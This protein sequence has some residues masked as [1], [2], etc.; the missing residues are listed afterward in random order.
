MNMRIQLLLISLSLMGLFSCSSPQRPGGNSEMQRFE[1]FLRTQ[2]D[3]LSLH[4]RA[5]RRHA[6]LR[7]KETTDSL[8][9][10]NYL[11][12]V[13][14]THLATADLDSSRTLIGKVG[15][16]VCR[17]IAPSAS[18]D[19]PSPI[20]PLYADLHSEVL[21]LEGNLYAKNGRMD[22][23]SY[24][25]R[26]AYEQR[27]KGSKPEAIPDILIN[28]ADAK[29]RLGRLD[30]GARWYR[31]A[32]LLCDS[33]QW[34]DNRKTPIY[35][36]LAQIYV[37]LRNFPLCDYYNDLAA[38]NYDHMLPFEKHFYLNNRGTSYYYREDYR[39]AISYFKQAVAL[40]RDYPDLAF[41]ENLSLLNLGDCYLG[42]N[43]PDSAAYYMD[44]CRPFFE[45]LDIP[46]VNYYMTTQ[47]I[48]LGVLQ[49]D[50]PRVRRLISRSVTPEGIDPEMVHIR[51]KYL[52]HYYEAAGDYRQAYRYLDANNRMDDSIRS[53]RARMYIAD[54]YAHYRQDS[55]AMA[56][57]MLL[58]EHRNE[59]LQLRNTQFLAVGIALIALL[60]SLFLYHYNK[61][62]RA[63]LRA[64][65]SRA[66]SVLRLE[67]VRNR[68]SP[69]FIFNVLNQK[70][71]R[72]PEESRHE[73]ANLVR[74]MRR[75]LELSEQLC[76]TLKEELDFI[77]TYIELERCNMGEE[78]LPVIHV[79]DN[80]HAERVKLPAMLLQI[81]V[82]NAIKHALRGKEGKRCLWLEI[83]RR[84]KGTFIRI[85]DNGG[86]YRSDN[87]HRGTG[88]GM[89]I[90]MQTIQILN[91]KNREAIEVSVHNVGLPDGETGCEVTFYLPDNYNYQI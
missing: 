21:N 58:Q 54:V 47:A 89:R 80:V 90:I 1:D 27:L 30:A 88:T 6:L 20:D 57:R 49:N 22:S 41:E 31:R 75:N 62:K 91:K 86:G 60:L 35:Y 37:S 61:K 12:L 43:L 51:N 87:G 42:L 17:H 11:A 70:I 10:Y 83:V 50:L 9:Y 16:Y 15:K 4:P 14:K 59:V 34:D 53:G 79:D 13:A 48:Q 40:R 82:E 45:K 2:G 25:F 78:F 38:R 52:L 65:S 81:P 85:A 73:F 74:L 18:G 44:A 66:V 68:L 76:V 56:H 71:S 39:T 36:G 77:N 72:L 64:E 46:V 3:S 33:L 7:M 23:A 26:R 5:V 24:C 19:R 32:L 84:A 55:T 67:N 63:L 29:N 8:A 28:L 69:H